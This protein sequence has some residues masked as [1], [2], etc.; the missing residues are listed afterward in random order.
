MVVLHAQNA[1][2]RV[3]HGILTRN[4]SYVFTAMI[5][6]TICSNCDTLTML[7]VVSESHKHTKEQP[8]FHSSSN[9]PCLS[10]SWDKACEKYCSDVVVHAEGV[11]MHSRIATY[12]ELCI[13]NQRPF[14]RNAPVSVYS[15]VVSV[16]HM[17]K[18][19]QIA[20]RRR[21]IQELE[22]Q[23]LAGAPDGQGTVLSSPE[24]TSVDE[25]GGLRGF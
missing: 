17:S 16:S 12:C 7:P 10:E 24:K 5:N 4:C 14:A 21:I 6:N 11:R 18:E 15:F 9:R 2:K 3:P 25:Q 20:K 19:E 8:Q 1:R 22:A 23:S 13:S